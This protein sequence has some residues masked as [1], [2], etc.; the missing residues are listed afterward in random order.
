VSE[1]HLPR[2]A[3]A[4]RI[5]LYGSPATEIENALKPPWPRW[6]RRLYE[7]ER[8]AGA[9]DP[10]EGEVALSVAIGA[11]GTRLRHRIE[12]ISWCV[13]AVEEIGW[14]TAVE[15]DDVIAYKVALPEVARRELEDHGI[16]GPLTHVCEL[17]ERGLPRL[18]ERWQPS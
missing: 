7:L 10:A 2:G 12:L 16:Q 15:G 6:M 13:S 5:R 1:L 9:A 18:I 3:V 4:V 17:D 11:V 8:Y 14:Q